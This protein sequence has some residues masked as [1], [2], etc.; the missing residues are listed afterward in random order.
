MTW[1]AVMRDTSGNIILDLPT[2]LTRVLGTVAVSTADGSVTNAAL[3]EPNARVW[4]KFIGNGTPPLASL[5]G[6]TILWNW[7]TIHASRRSDKTLI[8]GLF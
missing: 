7:S 5:S 8:Y 4:W 2:R 3:G 1:R 6:T